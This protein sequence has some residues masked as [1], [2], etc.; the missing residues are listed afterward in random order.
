MKKQLKIFIV[1]IPFL[2]NSCTKP[3]TL[4]PC[5]NGITVEFEGILPA[6]FSVSMKGTDGKLL[7]T[8]QC[9]ANTTCTSQI[10]FPN[11]NSSS[12]MVD[13]TRNGSTVSETFKPEYK[14]DM[15]N[16]AGCGECNKAI[17]KYMIK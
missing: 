11:I 5:E 1:I 9:N 3:C 10:F 7:G 12:V 16:G 13:L 15:P 17:V 6:E 4:L 14:T 2:I 8:R